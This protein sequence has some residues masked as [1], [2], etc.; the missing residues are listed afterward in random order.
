M[1]AA[2]Y[3]FPRK[4]VPNS[5][6]DLKTFLKNADSASDQDVSLSAL[7]QKRKSTSNF[8]WDGDAAAG[9]LVQSYGT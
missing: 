5:V 3:L 6:L 1:Y 2:C 8:P 9:S 7:G 4:N